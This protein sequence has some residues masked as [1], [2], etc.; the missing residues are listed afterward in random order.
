[1]DKSNA[2]VLT[3]GYLDVNTNAGITM[4]PI[5]LSD[6]NIIKIANMTGQIYIE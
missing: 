1:M 6:T 3:A 4:S 5:I 2:I